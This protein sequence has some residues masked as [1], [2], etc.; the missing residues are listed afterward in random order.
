M[1]SCYTTAELEAMRK[2]RL[3]QE[4]KDSIQALKTKMETTFE[5]KAQISANENIKLTVVDDDI[6]VN[7]YQFQG[8]IGANDTETVQ[9]YERDVLDFSALL[10]FNANALSTL[11]VKLKSLIEQIKERAILSRRD[12]EE[13]DRLEKKIAS[14]IDDTAMDIE[15]KIIFAKMRITSYLQAGSLISQVDKSQLLSNMMEYRVLCALIDM[16]PVE[17]LPEKVDEEILR[18][19]KILEKRK[20]D[21]YI[22]STLTEIMEDLGCH[23]KEE[24]ILDYTPGQLFSVDGHPLCDVF[25]G[26]DGNGIMFE[27]IAES[28]E[29]SLDRAR[30]IQSS[31]NSICSLYSEI[32]ERAAEKGIILRN[33]YIT[34]TDM[35]MISVRSDIQENKSKKQKNGNHSQQR[36]MESEA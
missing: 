35:E 34:P 9:S 10:T 1:S 11:E 12:V 4:L 23:M 6:G 13:R 21:E 17:S 7:G 27:A 14:L 36:M 15:D 16:E 32:E 19:T 28:R 22:M 18:L 29:G 3:R 2:E 30:Q 5:N 24:S 33:V 8:T 25:M 31:A 20:Q 26:V